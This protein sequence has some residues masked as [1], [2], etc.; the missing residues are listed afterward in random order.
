MHVP[1]L[2]IGSIH[3]AAA[4]TAGRAKTASQSFHCCL[5]AAGVLTIAHAPAAASPAAVA[6]VPA[7]AGQLASG[8]SGVFEAAGS[9]IASIDARLSALQ[10]FLRKAKSSAAAS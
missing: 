10:D 2:C 9:E 4:L 1:W 6:A 7:A 3:E 8:G 5:L